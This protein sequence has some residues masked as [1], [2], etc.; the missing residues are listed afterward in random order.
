MRD[1]ECFMD[2]EYNGVK[3]GIGNK[4][5]F[6]ILEK[7]SRYWAEGEAEKVIDEI[8]KMRNLDTYKGIPVSFL[9]HCFKEA[10]EA[11]SE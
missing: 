10:I 9:V 2:Y 8:N 5:T 3:F 1:R 4:G 11:F 7:G 6:E